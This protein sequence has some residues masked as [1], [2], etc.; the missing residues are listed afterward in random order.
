MALYNMAKILIVDDK[1]DIVDVV[2]ILLSLHGYTVKGIL[3]GEET[4]EH[5]DAFE[6]DLILLDILLAGVDGREI[7]KQIKSHHKLCDTPVIL[8]SAID[9]LKDEPPL[10]SDDF[11]AKPFCIT[12]LIQKVKKH[13]KAA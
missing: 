11:L 12:D 7:C 4:I 2:K 13:I 3:R 8:F 6:P 9:S 5:A 10:Y 1:E